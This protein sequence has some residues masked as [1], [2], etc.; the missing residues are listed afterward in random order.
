[1]QDDKSIWENYV[2][3]GVDKIQVFWSTELFSLD[4]AF[5][6]PIAIQ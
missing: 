2:Q 5:Y 6:W 3:E 4:K 1:M